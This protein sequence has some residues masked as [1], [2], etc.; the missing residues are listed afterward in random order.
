MDP[1]GG[2]PAMPARIVS[3]VR[4]ALLLGAA[5]AA[6]LSSG[7]MHLG[8]A[9]WFHKDHERLT[10]TNS[11]RIDQDTSPSKVNGELDRAHELF[12][13]QEYASAGSA[14]EHIYKNT[15][16]SPAVAEEAMYYH[17]ESDR[18]RGH[19]T[20]AEGIYKKQLQEFPSGAFKQQGCQRLFDIAMLWLK[21]S[22]IEISDKLAGKRTFIIPA[23]FRINLDS[24][25]PTLDA[26]NRAL[27]ALEVVH[28]SDMTGPLADKAIFWAGF[29]KFY[30]EDYKE[31]DHYFTALLQYHK[32]SPLA[33]RACEMAIICKTYAAGGPAYD[34][35]KVAE[36]RQLIDTAMASYP[37][38]TQDDAAKKKM[39][40]RLAA[41]TAAQ[42]EKD[43][44]RAE[45]YERTHH[46]GSAYFIYELMRRSYPNTEYEKIATERIARLKPEMEKAEHPD[47]PGPLELARRRWNRMW[48]LDPDGDKNGPTLG[49]SPTALPAS[50]GPGR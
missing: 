14:F 37:E 31:A 45:L 26:E 32:D 36:A 35:R 10:Y 30:R 29:V 43:L 38:L 8:V 20:S 18:M 17:G 2:E 15:H 21:D 42:A 47:P 33:P 49:A 11:D 13:K 3:L 7:C 24:T 22:D 44:H 40:D 28:Y 34:G 48:G 16:N 12:R 6:L 23:E 39:M 50:L 46:P 25:K 9:D 41:V 19:L 4:P 27:Q 1:F 5:C